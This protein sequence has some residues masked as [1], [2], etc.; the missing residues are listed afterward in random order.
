MTGV[1]SRFKTKPGAYDGVM[2]VS[3]EKIKYYWT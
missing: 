1:I 3:F 2:R